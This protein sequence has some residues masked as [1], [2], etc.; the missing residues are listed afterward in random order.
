MVNDNLDLVSVMVHLRNRS[1]LG[2]PADPAIRLLFSDA[3]PV[4]G[5]VKQSR[6]PDSWRRQQ[7]VA[8]LLRRDALDDAG[9]IE[10]I[11]GDADRRRGA[12]P[13]DQIDGRTAS[14]GSGLATAE[15]TV[16]LRAYEE[17]APIWRMVARTADVQLD[18]SLIR[19]AGTVTG[20]LLVYLLPP[21]A[22]LSWPL[23]QDAVLA[24]VGF[25]G[26][27]IMCTAYWPTLKLYEGTIFWLPTLPFAALLYT[28]MTIDS[29]RL[30][31]QGRGGFWKGRVFQ[32]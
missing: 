24:I 4:R 26:W 20:M 25:F 30:Y 3:V 17:L 18:H 16:S 8:C 10:A 27:L 23:H 12:R 6:E 32:G 2:T 5:M 11:S 14:G 19:L 31:R 22:A 13:A 1:F 9:G 28:A 7:A 21:L 15:R 29:A